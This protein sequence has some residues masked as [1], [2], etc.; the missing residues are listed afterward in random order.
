MSNL[1]VIF[2]LDLAGGALNR[3]LRE[4]AESELADPPIACVTRR[5]MIVEIIRSIIGSMRFRLIDDL[6]KSYGAPFVDR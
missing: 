2:L 4:K 6:E 3:A 1:R 5:L